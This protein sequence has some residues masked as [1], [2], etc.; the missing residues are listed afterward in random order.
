MTTIAL[1]SHEPDSRQARLRLLLACGVSVLL[2]LML[3]L[4]VPVNPTGGLPNAAP[5]LTARLES[6]AAEATAESESPPGIAT[7]PVQ[8]T[9][10]PAATNEPAKPVESK[11]EAR[12]DSKSAA[13][14]SKAAAPPP[15]SPSGGLELPLIRDP[16]YYPARQLDVYPQPLAAIRPSC[17]PAA[18][19]GRINGRVQLL[20][21][22]DEFGVVNDASVVESQAEGFF[23]EPALSAFRTAR[24]SPGQKQGR[25]VKSRV[26]L[27]V[28]F[29][30][31]DNEGTS[32]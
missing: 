15:P 6:A 13:P 18:V 23:D 30:C 4:G 5:T 2:H 27:R 17:P 20:L 32:R 22:I 14:E 29:L 28:N 3:L 8:E 25:N 21:L 11:T 31:A 1:L 10:A 26:L 7:P 12:P 16:V 9:P 19:A 24:F